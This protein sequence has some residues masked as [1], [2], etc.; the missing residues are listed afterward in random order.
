[1]MLI[2]RFLLELCLLIALGYWGFQ[3]DAG[4]F[5]RIVAGLGAPLFAA[6]LWGLFVAP[7]AP[8]L[9]SEPWRFGLEI[10]LFGLGAGALWLADRPALGAALIIV[11]LINRL[12]LMIRE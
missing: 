10:I 5:T 11:F 3:L 8:R 2:I 12:L 9:L 6:V 4:W 1:M 7:K